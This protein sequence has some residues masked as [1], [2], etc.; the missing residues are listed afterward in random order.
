MGKKFIVCMLLCS[1]AVC[2][3][4]YAESVGTNIANSVADPEINIPEHHGAIVLLDNDSNP[5]HEPEL[6]QVDF[7]KISPPVS[8]KER[9]DRLVQGVSIDIPPEYDHY[10][11]ELRRYM[12]HVGNVQI[13]TDDNFRN[14]QIENVKKAKIIMDYWRNHLKDEII[15]LE[16]A[17]KSQELSTTE[18]TAYKQNIAE[19]NNFLV[20]AQGWLDS[21]LEFL[22]YLHAVSGK[23][24]YNYPRLIFKP[25]EK[26]GLLEEG[27]ELNNMTDFV[28]AS[29]GSQQYTLPKKLTRLLKNKQKYLIEVRRFSNF[30]LMVY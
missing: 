23:Y 21:N 2:M 12:Q 7:L 24:E 3:P 26:K 5:P 19:V 20:L 25:D 29:E 14:E 30:R 10:G 17:V 16:E 27:R 11:Y 15:S 18:N 28:G 22:E 8:L 13:Y 4:A 1:T 9:I 6:L